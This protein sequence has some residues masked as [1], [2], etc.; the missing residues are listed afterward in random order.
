MRP[1]RPAEKP[2]TFLEALDEKYASGVA[3]DKTPV[4]SGPQIVVSGKVA[5]EIGF[6]KIRLQQAQLHELKI[7]ILDGLRVASSSTGS[8]EK[9]IRDVCPKVAELDLSRNILV[10]FGTVVD[11]CSHLDGLRGLRV[12]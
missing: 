7:V 8:Q 2:R 3:A 10:N 5:E 4:S 6:D 1:T 9:S 11:I 12:K